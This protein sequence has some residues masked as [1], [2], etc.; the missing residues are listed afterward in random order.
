LGLEEKFIPTT[1]TMVCFFLIHV[2][3]V[4]DAVR[5]P[6]FEVVDVVPFPD[7][8]VVDVVLFPVFEVVD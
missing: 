6:V 7:F 8:E 5:F 4:V 1:K 2:F 3:E